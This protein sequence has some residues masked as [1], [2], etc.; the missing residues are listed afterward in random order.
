MS[1]ADDGCELSGSLQGTLRIHEKCDKRRAI[2]IHFNAARAIADFVEKAG[3][4]PGLLS[5]HTPM[6]H[7]SLPC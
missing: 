6:T 4:D 1:R 3:I 5:N 2:G 7:T